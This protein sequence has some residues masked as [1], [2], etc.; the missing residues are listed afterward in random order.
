MSSDAIE[1]NGQERNDF[2]AM[3]RRIGS[4]IRKCRERRGIKVSALARDVAKRGVS[5]DPSYLSRMERGAV[6][7]PLRTLLA[8][9]RALDV[10]PGEVIELQREEPL[11]LS[12]LIPEPSIE[13]LRYLAMQNKRLVAEAL[14]RA[15]QLIE[16]VA[17]LY[18]SGDRAAPAAR[19]K[20]TS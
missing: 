15:I 9:C 12:E 3:E 2:H 4:A 13:K 10:S 1:L 7:I 5:C 19:E 11:S 16:E 18:E 17:A 20:I 6:A 14:F 8:L